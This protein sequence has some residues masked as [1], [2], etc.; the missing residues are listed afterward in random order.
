[1]SYVLIAY[2]QPQL[3]L[4]IVLRANIGLLH[5]VHVFHAILLVLHAMVGYQLNA[6]PVKMFQE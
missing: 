3:A 4:V 1:V 6:L 2:I 5:Q